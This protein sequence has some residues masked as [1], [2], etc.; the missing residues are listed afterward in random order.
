MEPSQRAV[1]KVVVEA[2]EST[3]IAGFVTA[4]PAP[5]YLMEDVAVAW[6]RESGPDGRRTRCSVKLVIAGGTGSLGRRVAR[7]T[8][9]PPARM[10]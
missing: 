5:A 10:S 9:L 2:L 1:R 3:F 8:S 6:D 7:N 4:T